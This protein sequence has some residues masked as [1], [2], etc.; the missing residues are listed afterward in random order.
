MKTRLLF[1]WLTMAMLSL[2]GTSAMAQTEI[3]TLQDLKNVK[4]NLSGQYILMA[5][6]DCGSQNW[7]PIGPDSDHPFKGVFNGNG[8]T[9]TYRMN[10]GYYGG[11][12][13]KLHGKVSNLIVKGTID[14]RGMYVGG[15]AAYI[16]EGTILNCYSAVDICSGGGGLVGGIAGVMVW[17]GSINFCAASGVI[18]DPNESNEYVGGI[19]GSISNPYPYYKTTLSSCYFTG[20]IA[21]KDNS[22][23]MIYGDLHKISDGGEVIVEN[24]VF[25]RLNAVGRESK[26]PE[27]EAKTL[28]QLIAQGNSPSFQSFYSVFA[29]GILSG[30]NGEN[31]SISSLSDL[32]KIGRDSAYPLDGNYTLTADIDCGKENW[33]PIGEN[34]NYPFEGV[35]DGNG[36]TITYRTYRTRNILNNKQG[37]FSEVRSGTVK[38][39]NVAGFISR[40]DYYC[41]G[42]AGSCNGGT[43]TNCYS[44]VDV[45]GD[46]GIGGIVGEV[47]NDGVISYCSASGEIKGRKD[48]GGIV[49][50]VAYDYSTLNACAFTGTVVSTASKYVGMITGDDY[51]SVSR[52][53]YLGTNAA[54]KKGVGISSGSTDNGTVSQTVSELRSYANDM[55]QTTAYRVY[56]RGIL[57]SLP[58]YIS[59]RND[60]A[61]IGNDSAYPIDGKY[62]LTENINCGTSKWTPIGSPYEFRGVFDGGGHTITYII[63]GAT[64]KDQ[65]LFGYVGEKGVV[66]NLNVDGTVTGARW[67]FGGVAGGNDGRISNCYSSV[68]VNSTYGGEQLAGGITGWNKGFVTYC[69][70]SGDVG[71]GIDVG[72][73]V[74]V[75][76]KGIIYYCTFTGHITSTATNRIGMIVGDNESNTLDN[77]QDCYYYNVNANGIKGIG[78]LNSST[79]MDSRTTAPRGYDELKAY[80]GRQDLANYQVYTQGILRGLPTPIASVDELRKIGTD[81]DYPLNGSYI[82]TAN[83]DCGTSNWTPIGTQSNGFTGVFDGNGFT[84]TYQIVN[85][86]NECTGLFGAIGAGGI[87][88]NLNV[89]GTLTGN[90]TKYGSISGVNN[91]TITNCNSRMN[92]TNSF[93]NWQ[94]TGGI[95]GSNYGVVSYCVTSGKMETAGKDVGGI[96]GYNFQGIVFNCTFTG[97]LTTTVT[98]YVGLIVGQNADSGTTSNCYYF[99]E[100]AGSFKGEGT[101]SWSVDTDGSTAPKYENELKDYAFSSE[102]TNYQVYAQGILSGLAITDYIKIATL[103]DLKKIGKNSAYPLNG[104]YILTADINCGTNTSWTPIGNN[105]KPFLGTFNGDGHTITYNI[106]GATTPFQGLFGYIVSNGLVMNLEVQGSVSSTERFVGGIAGYNSGTIFNCYS[107][108]KVSVT[109]K[110]YN[111]VGGIAGGNYYGTISYCSASGAVAGNY[112]GQ[113]GIVGVLDSG[114][115]SHCTY[116]GAITSSYPNHVGMVCGSNINDDAITDC[117]YLQELAG[118]CKGLDGE[119]AG[120]DTEGSTAPMTVAAM[121]DYANSADLAG[122]QVYVRGI[123]KGLPTPIESENDLRKIGNDDAYPLNGNYVLMDNLSLWEESW[124]PIGNQLNSDNTY[125]NKNFDGNFYGNGLTIS[126][127]IEDEDGHNYQGLFGKIGT[128]GTVRDLNVNA[129]ISAS[130]EISG[131]I[132]GYNY[133]TI[134]NCYVYA[135]IYATQSYGSI[136]G[137]NNR[138]TISYC[139]G[140]GWLRGD[141]M[142]VGGIVGM[143]I[144]QGAVNNC[145]YLGYLDNNETMFTGM[146][147]GENSS[148]AKMT[149]CYY[150]GALADRKGAGSA[151]GSIDTNGCTS[152]LTRAEVEAYAYREKLTMFSVYVEGLLDA[153][154]RADDIMTG[155]VAPSDESALH[156]S[157][158]IYNLSGQ[159]VGKDYKGIVIKNGKKVLMK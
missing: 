61:K 19:V 139:A 98:D 101:S 1:L 74:G 100:N 24:C 134:T 132:V 34:V 16:Q 49:G 152:P 153:L 54:G 62:F 5:D 66:R 141:G 109:N 44:A 33:R 123:L 4:N 32:E 85:S 129:D 8:H 23:G 131:G 78:T 27:C 50:R 81:A 144:I 150:L 86:S 142:N 57:N 87:V 89:A 42:I 18:G 21:S 155:I 137:I 41:G 102:L 35:F 96:V 127:R 130:G 63:D 7:E 6:I 157:E 119:T 84:V 135:D 20:T 11:L 128:N 37:L 125:V 22:G 47:Y 117:N 59:S 148:D 45:S 145:T 29:N 143:N 56:A 80:A 68:N 12:F 151:D 77:I 138:G 10:K 133:G 113:G 3:W 72:G 88:K 9:I 121:Q 70:A 25:R 39:L 31:I 67:N 46:L 103:S 156:E 111:H 136:A 120:T 110:A 26:N 92:I 51:S 43:I 91:G 71:E 140:T 112:A 106:K 69:S 55:N 116:L 94:I 146:V 83:I 158:T 97:R 90:G 2:V 30:L 107:G 122:Y 53:Y 40:K 108:V 17:G 79:D 118:V 93:N 105:D 154:N 99:R 82:L 149:D 36:H 64:S 52:S 13:G 73:I 147:T 159:V 76:A 65:G 15:I 14:M 114:T 124:M 126:Y 104:N 58:I 28:N 75:N 60:L 48:V 95:T 38:N 115:I